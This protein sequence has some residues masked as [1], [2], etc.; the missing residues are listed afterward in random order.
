MR[1]ILLSFITVLLL[2]SCAAQ[3]PTTVSQAVLPPEPTEFVAVLPTP[4]AAKKYTASTAPVKTTM[5]KE[6]PAKAAST[7]KEVSSH[8]LQQLQKH[9]VKHGLSSSTA[10]RY[11]G[12][13]MDAATEFDLDPYLILA[14]ISVETG[15]TFKFKSHPNSHG[16]IGLMQILN[17]NAKGM[18]V[19]VS[20]LYDPKTN[21]HLGSKY[22][23]YLQGRFGYDKGITAYNQG[24]GNV[25]RGT[26]NNKYLRAVKST[27]SSI[28][29]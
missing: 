14:I 22:L 21:I 1:K 15:K 29:K 23:K 16:A 18:G 4:A 12:Y 20:D 10:N 25:S 3:N 11:A 17:R 27:Y 13:I 2:T 7:R 6:T 9:M 8:K 24:E 26:Y 19:S 28:G 5:T